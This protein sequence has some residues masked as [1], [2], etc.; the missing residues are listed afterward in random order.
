ML[1][2]EGLVLH[3][4][5]AIVTRLIRLTIADGR[6]REEAVL[7]GSRCQV[8]LHSDERVTLIL[9]VGQMAAVVLTFDDGT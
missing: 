1:V 2:R 4:L 9:L 6:A 7:L 3:A 5:L 8:L